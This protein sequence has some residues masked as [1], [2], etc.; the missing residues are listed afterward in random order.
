MKRFFRS[1]LCAAL[2]ASGAASALAAGVEP[3][4]AQATMLERGTSV[5]M[6]IAGP[7]LPVFELPDPTTTSARKAAKLRALPLPDMTV[8]AV[9]TTDAGHRRVELA[10]AGNPANQATLLWSLRQDDPAAHFA[11]GQTVAF[12][13]N[14]KGTGWMLRADDGAVLA[15]VPASATASGAPGDNSQTP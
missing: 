11:V 4:T 10:T 9:T 7:D 2:L 6:A 1:A 12:T 5:V 3:T 8:R 15:F 14:A 13:L